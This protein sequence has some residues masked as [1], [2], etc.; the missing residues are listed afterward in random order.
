MH[1]KKSFAVLSVAALIVGLLRPQQPAPVPVVP[2]LPQAARS[3][4]DSIDSEKIRAH[5]R[6][7]SLDLLE[8]AV[9]ARA[10]QNLPQNT[11]LPSSH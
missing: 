8:G 9:P 3:G 1:R 5:V 4:A 10:E 7:L 2:G 11:S 6:F